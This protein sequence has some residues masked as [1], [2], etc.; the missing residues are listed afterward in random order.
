MTTTS[1][2]EETASNDYVVEK[3]C[4][5]NFRRFK[6]AEVEFHGGLNILV[7]GNDQGKSTVIGA[8]NLALTGRWQGR[9]F[10]AELN[11]HFVNH[12]AAAEYLATAKQN[13]EVAPEPP[14][15]VVEV[16]LKQ[17]ENTQR[18][19]GNNNDEGR[20]A[21]G[22]RIRAGL[23][24]ELREEYEAFIKAT[25]DL[26]RVPTEFYKVEWLGFHGATVNPR[27]LPVRSAIIDATRIHLQSGTDYYLKNIM[28]GALDP[29][30]RSALSAKFRSAQEEFVTDTAV[31]EVNQ[32]LAENRGKVTQRELTLDV[33]ISQHNQWDS[34]LTPHLDEVPFS[35]L[36]SG[37][38]SKLKIMLALSRRAEDV[39][40]IMIEEPEN[41]L[42]FGE[43]TK[44][45]RHIQE[46]NSK[47]QLIMATHSSFVINKLGLSNLMLLSD[48][49]AHSL[50]DLS[51]GT[52]DY[53]A[54]LSGYDTLRLVLAEK[55]VL[56]EGPSDEL[57]VQKAYKDLYGRL[58]IEDGI[59]VINVRG[60]SAPRFL[61]L[62]RPLKRR[63][64]VVT[65]NDGKSASVESRY[66]HYQQESF[67]T[68]CIGHADEGTTLE[69]QLVAANGADALSA[70]FGTNFTSDQE[71]S[72][73]MKKRKA[74][75]ALTLFG[76]DRM[77][78]LPR[79]LQ[80]ALDA[81]RE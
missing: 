51:A 53:F 57:I 14:E 15:I 7:G 39:D 68:I 30:Q 81:L 60:L 33:D 61:E 24:R 26:R 58:P 79:Y 54:K 74:E 3:L 36:G 64:V 13:P 27:A 2:P 73:W 11:P 48:E 76:S 44:L 25:R 12:D 18:L 40:V 21:T 70:I 22:L 59:D 56:V 65:D 43:L 20:P 49:S 50:Q 77:L 71:A 9:N 55:V 45:I 32:V 5:R 38:Q 19:T 66:V 31:A 8:L 42:A 47:H 80:E 78:H 37:E 52:A 35:M 75:V 23:D 16:H 29:A 34:A 10:A 62:A 17:T 72:E 6:D 4:L 41:H 46:N 63:C 28:S 67:F 69:D 1:E